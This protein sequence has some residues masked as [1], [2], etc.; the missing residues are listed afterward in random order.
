MPYDESQT[1]LRLI[2]YVETNGMPLLWNACASVRLIRVRMQAH[3]SLNLTCFDVG[4][5]RKPR[6]DDE[7]YVASLGLTVDDSHSVPAS[8]LAKFAPEAARVLGIEWCVP[9][10]N[11]EWTKWSDEMQSWFLAYFEARN[12]N[13]ALMGFEIEPDS[14]SYGGPGL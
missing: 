9:E 3:Y 6:I 10:W 12:T 13:L 2:P 7:E 14:S 8:S 5:N 11:P 4:W 1:P